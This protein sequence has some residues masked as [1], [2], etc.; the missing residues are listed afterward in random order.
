[1]ISGSPQGVTYD[2]VS[3]DGIKTATVNANTIDGE[4]QSRSIYHNTEN[5]SISNPKMR[6]CQQAK[7]SNYNFLQVI[8]SKAEGNSVRS[9]GDLEYQAINA[10]NQINLD[11]ID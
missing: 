8:T 11:L 4:E 10:N 2:A 1:M 3:D 9:Q 7:T 5:Q 6:L